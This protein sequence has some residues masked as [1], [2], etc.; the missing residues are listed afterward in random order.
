MSSL[1]N[2][3]ISAAI[4]P[5][6]AEATREASTGDTKFVLSPEL[7]YF[8]ELRLPQSVAPSTGGVFFYPLILNPQSIELTEPFS[9]DVAM[10]QGG[11]IFVE[12]NGIIQRSLR[13]SGTFGFYP[14]GKPKAV[15]V[16]NQLAST[17]KSY[18]RSLPPYIVN[19][20]SGMR[21]LQYLQDA[22]FRTYADLKRNPATS[23]DTQLIFHDSK[24]DEHWVVI[25]REFT[26]TAER[27]RPLTEDYRMEL[28]IVGPADAV[29]AT[30]PSEDAGLLQEV[31]DIQANTKKF[32][33]MATAALQDLTGLEQQLKGIVQGFATI[34]GNVT[35]L[36]TA[37]Q[38]F[39]T[40]ATALI[41]SPLTLVTA[42]A[43]LVESGVAFYANLI[44]SGS[45][46]AQIP[47]ATLQDLR[48]MADACDVLGQ[49]PECF[50]ATAQTALVAV[51]STQQLI[52]AGV[53]ALTLAATSTPPQNFAAVS[54]LGTALLP[55]D[56]AR[57]A[58]QTTVGSSVQNY[59][60]TQQYTVCKGD[61]LSNIASRFLGDARLWQ[62][63]AVAN[64]LKPP[65]LAV[66]A[67]QPLGN[68][69]EVSLPGA[70][71]LGA[72]ILIPNN[73]PAPS[74]LPNLP[75]LGATPN[76][77]P[78]VH[79]FGRDLLLVPVVTSVNNVGSSNTQYDLAVNTDGA[80]LDFL[81]V[82]GL[83]NLQQ[84]L[85]TRLTT[86][87]GANVL[88][89]QVGVQQVVAFNIAALDLETIRFRI[90]A[91]LAADPRVAAVTQV[92]ISQSS[93]AADTAV[94]DAT[95]QPRGYNQPS[96]IQVTL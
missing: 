71:G 37:A 29:N 7:L 76:D 41:E 56:A 85:V 86:D 61:T 59:T 30:R 18:A 25:P 2:A 81:T 47:D 68:L 12:E 51:K 1:L 39:V 52:F 50:Q 36:V 23:A 62:Y 77:P 8:F 33:N 70:L 26:I 45:S 44:A 14:K 48:Q 75:V 72:T 20:I 83:P 16:L 28:L 21:H 54:A 3:A 46:I 11:G 87:K 4:P 78:A 95:V 5:S 74:S 66:Q 32:I 24:K 22:V 90:Q 89:Q 19:A 43:G 10:T 9:V 91:A 38:N 73:A 27:N 57:A 55:G 92:L 49:H 58:A 67:G 65:F 80:S 84:G 34:I 35:A 82:Q 15:P 31:R 13:I 42:T 88:Y 94:V 40:G 17:N 93:A 69:S 6:I 96:S 63:I 64:G 79:L 53:T 60:S